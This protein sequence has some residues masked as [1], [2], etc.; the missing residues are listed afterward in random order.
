M[1][2]KGRL[3]LAAHVLMCAILRVCFVSVSVVNVII[4]STLLSTQTLHLR[5]AYFYVL[6]TVHRMFIIPGL[7]L[8]ARKHVW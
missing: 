4:Y 6:Y 8:C 1:D 3:Y 2:G 7:Q 5:G